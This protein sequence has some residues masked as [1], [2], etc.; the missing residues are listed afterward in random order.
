M[1]RILSDVLGHPQQRVAVSPQDTH[2]LT[3]VMRRRVGDFVEVLARDGQIWLGEWLGEGTIL[4][5]ELALSGWAPRRQ[6]ILYQALLK[7]DHFSEVVD[8]ATQVGVSRIVPLV[9]HRCIVRDVTLNRMGRWR[10][11]AKE[12][13]EQSR[14]SG[15]P[16]LE[17]L[18]FAEK[19]TAY[20]EAESYVLA[21]TARVD[22]PWLKENQ[23]PLELVVG[24]EGGLTPLEIERLGERGFSSLSIGHQVFRS[25][26]AGSFAALLFLQ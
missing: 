24:P 19:L 8:R 26:N 11:I 13:S 4:L 23:G 16:E 20:P 10:A 2:Y 1:V 15:V 18:A 6:V 9:T 3:A 22:R 12:A 21:P 7:G 5:K 14:R 17:E 25:E